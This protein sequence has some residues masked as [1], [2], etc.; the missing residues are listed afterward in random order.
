[1]RA[2]HPVL[3]THGYPA[4]LPAA[5]K[6]QQEIWYTNTLALTGQMLRHWIIGRELDAAYTMTTLLFRVVCRTLF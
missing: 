1:M 2:G 3:P 6:R 5:G 4:L